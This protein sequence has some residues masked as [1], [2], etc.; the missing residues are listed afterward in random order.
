MKQLYS[1]ILILLII[2]IW[3][4]SCDAVKRLAESEY[5]LTNNTV[6]IDDKKDNR[7]T[8]NNLIFQKPN[9]KIV[10]FPLRLHI[11][12]MARPN[13]DSIIEAQFNK[14]PKRREKYENL[15]SKKQLDKYI[16]SRIGFNKWLKKTGEAPVIID[17]AETKK[18]ITNFEKYFINNG[19][20]DVKTGYDIDRKDNKR[21][22]VNYNVTKGIPFMLDTI[23]EKIASPIIDS[24][25]KTIKKGSLIF[26]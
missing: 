11:Y 8:I 23:S 6:T 17:E 2:T 5:L 19:F 21:A 1:K 15:L 3:F 26:L 4:S 14:T 12:N 10:G 20:F 7:E 24:L 9:R 16:D 22:D 18:S 13:I 25:Y